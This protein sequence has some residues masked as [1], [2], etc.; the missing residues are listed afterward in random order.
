MITPFLQKKTRM[1]LVSPSLGLLFWMLVSFSIVLFILGKFAWPLILKGLKDREDF[2]DSALKSAEK[3]KAEMENLKS[4]NEKILNEARAERY[5]IIQEGKDIKD[6]VVSEAKTIAEAEARKIIEAAK[7][8]I[9][10]EQAAAVDET[11]NLIA[12][13]SVSIAE[14]LLKKN[15]SSDAS[16]QE[17]LNQVINEIKLN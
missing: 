7:E 2:I 3:A 15:L 11:K 17:Y 13:L 6:K 8:T 12:N 4:D 14:K 9:K 10:K 1:E 5:K 16:Q